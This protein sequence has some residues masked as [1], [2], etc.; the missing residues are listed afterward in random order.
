M[1]F[2]YPVSCDVGQADGQ[3]AYKQYQ[4]ALDYFMMVSH[5]MWGRKAIRADSQAMK[6]WSPVPPSRPQ[7]TCR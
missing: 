3:E 6:C 2:V 5:L 7:L 4:D 1:P